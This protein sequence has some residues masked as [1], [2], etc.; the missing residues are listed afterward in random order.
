MPPTQ[1]F[2]L[3]IRMIDKLVPGKRF[4]RGNLDITLA[5]CPAIMGSYS[6]QA[7]GPMSQI[8]PPRSCTATVYGPNFTLL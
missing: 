2:H 8:K 1:L 7:H 4:K 6:P 5:L 3:P